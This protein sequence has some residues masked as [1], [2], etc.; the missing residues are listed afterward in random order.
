MTAT[1]IIYAAFRAIGVLRAGQKANADAYADGLDMLNSMVDA[2]NIERLMIPYEA[3]TEFA[4][5]PSQA[6][7]TLGP[8]GNWAL[9]TRP[10]HVERAGV[11]INT[12]TMPIEQP[13]EILSTQRWAELVPSKSI[14][15][16]LPTA[17]YVEYAYP[18]INCYPWPVPSSSINKVAL[19]TW[20]SLSAFADLT[21][22]YNMPQ[23]Y[24]LAL[25]F[26]LGVA[27]W[28]QFVVQNKTQANQAQ[29]AQ[30]K[31]MADAAKAKIKAL[32]VPQL[33]MRCDAALLVSA[34]RHFNWMTGQ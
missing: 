4:L 14:Q 3:R 33:E 10:A 12:G 29:F 5:T 6:V 8:A 30:V 20:A 25:R 17:L 34:G 1:A 27:L 19:Y 23:G 32:N 28:P 2:W 16:T 21:T 18:L 24:D 26:N 7:Y 31:S 9:P 11:V 13:I 15:T 22:N